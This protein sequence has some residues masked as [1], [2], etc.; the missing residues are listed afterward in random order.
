M[1]S[2]EPVRMDSSKWPAEGVKNGV[3]KTTITQTFST[4]LPHRPKHHDGVADNSTRTSK[5]PTYADI[6]RARMTE[7][8]PMGRAVEQEP[9]PPPLGSLHSRGKPLICLPAVSMSCDHMPNALLHNSTEPTAQPTVVDPLHDGA[10]TQGKHRHGA[11]GIPKLQDKPSVDLVEL[12]R[13]LT[14]PWRETYRTGYGVDI[15][16]GDSTATCA[17]TSFHTSSTKQRPKSVESS[18]SIFLVEAGDQFQDGVGLKLVFGTTE[19]TAGYLPMEMKMQIRSMITSTASRRMFFVHFKAIADYDPEYLPTEIGLRESVQGLTY[20]EFRRQYG[21]FYIAGF[22]LSASCEVFILCQMNEEIDSHDILR[23]EAGAH[24]YSI[25]MGE[26]SYADSNAQAKKSTRLDQLIRM[27]GCSKLA[28]AGTPV[29]SI[30]AA[31]ENLLQDAV[32]EKEF[33]YLNHYSTLDSTIPREIEN[34][35]I[36]LF[37][38][39]KEIKMHCK[40]LQNFLRHPA[41][42]RSQAERAKM[43]NALKVHEVHQQ[44]LAHPST[45]NERYTASY[46]IESNLRTLMDLKSDLEARYHLMWSVK[47]MKIE[48]KFIPPAGAS[49]TS[50]W[51]CGKSEHDLVG[52]GDSSQGN[53]FREVMFGSGQKALCVRWT[54]N[55]TAPWNRAP[56]SLLGRKQFMEFRTRRNQEHSRSKIA[57]FGAPRTSS[58]PVGSQEKLAFEWVGDPI[59]VLGWSL[60]VG[61]ICKESDIRVLGENNCILSNYLSIQLDTSK[62]AQ[63]T[64]QVMFVPQHSHKFPDLQVAH[65]DELR[66]SFSYGW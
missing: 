29:I 51:E 66:H 13:E 65:F 28:L 38:K 31:L 4:N 17:L 47:K 23:I 59:Y 30:K 61:T 54:A 16:T 62:A 10:E 50:R 34:V 7:S 6:A 12:K 64:C 46:E 11:A 37:E 15:S 27:K 53:E 58:I 60:S 33:A 14:L 44:N 63:W 18:H 40:T 22:K 19:I 56:D 26:L 20:P 35:Y 45:I 1:P 55:S 32:G 5:H 9:G 52:G 41:C 3:Q 57:S 39:S 49:R 25:I 21:D 24:L 42:H 2:Q 36:C 43:E 8:L 48:V